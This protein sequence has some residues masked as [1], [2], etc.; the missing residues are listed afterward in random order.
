MKY[1]VGAY[2]VIW[3]GFFLYTLKLE[4]Q[5]RRLER[6]LEDLRREKK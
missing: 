2:L 4:S 3:I 6:E 5:V 1:L